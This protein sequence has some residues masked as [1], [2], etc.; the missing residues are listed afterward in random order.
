LL[1]LQLFTLA[2]LEDANAHSD[3]DNDDEQDANAASQATEG[4]HKDL[5]EPPAPAAAPAASAAPAAPAGPAAK[6]RADG[7]AVPGGKARARQLLARA[8]A[9]LEVAYGPH[10]DLCVAARARLAEG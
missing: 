8:L 4:L 3:D 10:A 1:A 9:M 7:R 6:S 5:G 2:D